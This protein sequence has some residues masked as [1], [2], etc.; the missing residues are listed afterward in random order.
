MS[1]DTVLFDLDGTLLDSAPLVGRILNGM[2]ESQRLAPLSL[3]SYRQWISLG[4]ADLVGNAMEAEARSVA[5]LVQEF[6]RRYLELPTPMNTLFPGVTETVAALAASGIRLGICSNKPEHLCRKVLLETGMSDYFGSVVGGD[7]VSQPKPHRQP[8]D[9]AL[10]VLGATAP[11]A[12]L[13]GDSTVDQRAAHAAQLP[14]VFFT[15]GY[16][17]GVDVSAAYSCID[18]VTQ[19]RNIVGKRSGVNLVSKVNK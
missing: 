17:D 19:V 5:T 18:V 12:I 7:T 15:G 8:L 10:K 14:F 3:N 11:S 2:R 6:R 16:D 4:A 9:H 1:I 13:V